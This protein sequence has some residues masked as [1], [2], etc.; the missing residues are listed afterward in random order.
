[1]PVETQPYATAEHLRTPEDIALYIEAVLEDGDPAL[2]ADAIGVVARARGMA[3]IAQETG[4]SREQL[5][6]TLSERGNPQL[7]TLMGVLKAIGL[8]L[9]VK[10]IG[11]EA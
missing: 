5:Y 11:T 9:S 2:V 3:Q 7:D 1:M 8:R 6:R 10:P 4:R